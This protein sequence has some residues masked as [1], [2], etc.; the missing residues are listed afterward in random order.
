MT[1]PTTTTTTTTTTSAP[2]GGGG[3][4][5]PSNSEVKLEGGKSVKMSELEIGDLVQT[6]MSRHSF[7]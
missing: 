5:F 2:S 6:G 4:C 1:G 3:G 7:F